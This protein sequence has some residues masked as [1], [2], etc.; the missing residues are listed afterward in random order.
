[1]ASLQTSG[2]DPGGE[3]EIASYPFLAGRP[4]HQQPEW[5][6]LESVA[7][8]RK[9][10]AALPPLVSFADTARLRARLADVAHGRAYV[11]QAG[12]CAED[13]GES[14]GGYVARKVGLVEMLAG[15]MKMLTHK[16]VLSVGR[17]AGQYAKPRSRPTER[18]AGQELP[19]YR[20]HMVNSPEPDPALRTPDASRLLLCYRAASEVMGH[21]GWSGNPAGPPDPSPT[22]WTSHEAL[23]LD[24]EVP[25]TRRAEDGRLYLASTHWP[26]IGERTRQPDGAHVALVA[27]VA[28]PV[29]CKV[30]PGMTAK[31]LLALCERLDPDRDP[32]RL[33]LISRMG[34]DAVAHRLPPLVRAVR[35]AGHPAIWLCDPMHGNTLTAPNQLKTRLVETVLRETEDFQGA[36]RDSGGTAAGLHLEITPEDV[37]ECVLNESSLDHVG[38][39]YTTLCDPRLDPQQADRIVTAWR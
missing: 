27:A 29:A 4:A 10:L 37:T 8:A 7:A 12:D 38:K 6:D 24:Y 14:T 35:A 28:N 18:V 1:M 32:G 36:V 16:P 19:V 21:L 26:W 25:L 5:T 39:K 30:G 9:E 13:P 33:T 31:D 23:L 15:R 22:L 2:T 20:G 17:I 11:I 34:A 3:P